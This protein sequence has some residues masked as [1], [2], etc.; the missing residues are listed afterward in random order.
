MA[1]TIQVIDRNGVLK[2]VQPLQL[3]EQQPIRITVEER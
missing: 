1:T 3:R 2:P